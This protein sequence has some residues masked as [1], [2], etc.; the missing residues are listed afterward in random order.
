MSVLRGHP[1]FVKGSEKAIFSLRGPLKKRRTE[2]AVFLPCAT[3]HVPC[4]RYRHRGIT[5]QAN[6][7]GKKCDT[8]APWTRVRARVGS[9]VGHEGDRWPEVAQLASQARA[10]RSRFRLQLYGPPDMVGASAPM[11]AALDA[12]RLG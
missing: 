3:C 10:S 1:C 2:L 4:A 11:S 7:C 8:Q 5:R 12:G 9:A 6:H